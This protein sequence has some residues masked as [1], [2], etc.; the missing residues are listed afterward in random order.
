[1]VPSDWEGFHVFEEN[2]LVCRDGHYTAAR[3]DIQ[4]G[5]KLLK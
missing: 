4:L 5:L 2:P 3:E 1:V